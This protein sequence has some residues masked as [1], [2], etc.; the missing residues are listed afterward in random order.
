MLISSEVDPM[1]RTTGFGFLV[2]SAAVPFSPI[3]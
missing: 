1:L 3:H 2:G